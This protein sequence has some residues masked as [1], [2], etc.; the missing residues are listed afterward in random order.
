MHAPLFNNR[1]APR[2]G[3]RSGIDLG[4][5]SITYR[6]LNPGEARFIDEFRIMSFKFTMNH[7]QVLEKFLK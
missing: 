6:I 2:P 1:M 7:N 3:P 4:C 5:Q